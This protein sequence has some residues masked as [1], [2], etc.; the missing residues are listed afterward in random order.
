LLRPFFVLQLT[1]L[2]RTENANA[3]W[4][5]EQVSRCFPAVNV[6]SSSTQTEVVISISFGSMYLIIT[7][8]IT[9]TVALKCERDLQPQL[10][11]LAA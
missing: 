1:A 9:A 10:L 3:G 4:F 5:V 2:F 7:S 8:G 6:L 11:A